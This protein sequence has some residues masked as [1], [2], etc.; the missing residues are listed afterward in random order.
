MWVGLWERRGR[1]AEKRGLADRSEDTRSEGFPRI[2]W[3]IQKK[4]ASSLQEWKPEAV[5]PLPEI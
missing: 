3:G 4:G 5:L 2:W 1:A